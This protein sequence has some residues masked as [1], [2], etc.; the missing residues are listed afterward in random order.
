M[1]S[2]V[3]GMTTLSV[4][5]PMF[6][7]TAV[8]PALVTRLRPVLD[9]LGVD[10]EVV[11]V[12]DGSRDDTVAVLF[13]HGRDWPQ[14]RVVRL[15]R[16]S[17]HQA[18]LTAGLHRAVGRWVVS[19]DADLQDPP[20]VIADM[21][22]AAREDGVDV[23]Y[24]VRADR[25]TD[26]VFKRNTARVYYWLMRRLVGADLPA[27]A[28][29][30]RLLSRDVIEVLRRLP[31]RA[32]VY[33]LLVPSL[34][35]PSAEVRYVRAARVAG[36][37]KYPLRR[38][39]ALAWES[40]AN[41]SAAPLRLATWLGMCSFLLCLGLI[42]FGMVAYVAGAT[43][44]GWTSMFVAVLLLSGVQLVCLGLL[45]DYVGRIYATV[46]NRP[47]FHVGFDSL[48]DVPRAATVGPIGDESRAP[49]VGAR[50]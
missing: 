24:G 48:D 21:L 49:V 39:V 8:I 38:M 26:T 36:Q 3:P 16:N 23:V 41:F 9:A 35:F 14:L 13:D 12:D 17:G 34:G 45:G 32:P 6:N 46:Q 1:E 7:E 15:R 22:R 40:T 27:Q 43:I 37:T 25:S 28:G 50:G 4:V 44:P 19:L 30:F 2:V 5:V 18:A 20:E 10:Y 11:A 31:E 29:D 33:R 42:A 47:A